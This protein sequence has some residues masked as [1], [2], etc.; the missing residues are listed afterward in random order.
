LT[1]RLAAAAPER[2]AAAEEILAGLERLLKA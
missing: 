2:R 1:E